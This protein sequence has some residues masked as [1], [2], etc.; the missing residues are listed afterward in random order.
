[1]A[2]VTVLVNDFIERDPVIQK[3]LV[4]GLINTSALAKYM[5]KEGKIDASADAVVTAIRRNVEENGYSKKFKERKRM[6][7]D[8][9]VSSKNKMAF[10]VLSKAEST[11]K[12]LPD[13][14]NKVD[15]YGGDTIRLV[16]SSESFEILLDEKNLERALTLFPEDKVKKIKK[17][18]GV[19]TINLCQDD[20]LNLED[21]PG[22][23]ASILNELAINNINVLETL[24]C[25]YEIMIFVGEK[26][27]LKA[28]E[29]LMGLCGK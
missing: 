6:F 18:I 11:L 1:M 8:S 19:V 12:A 25:L 14:F 10:I 21:T 16:K 26:D 28:Y 22:V 9:R 13:L 29:V 4:R 20:Y 2:N 27:L 17:N 7:T 23:F 5:I 15:I 3:D 24:S